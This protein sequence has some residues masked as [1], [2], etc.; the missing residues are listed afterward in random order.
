VDTAEA[1]DVG[2]YNAEQYDYDAIV[3]DVM[4]PQL[5]GWQVLERLRK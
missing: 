5:D 3:L 2:L 4:L 1:G